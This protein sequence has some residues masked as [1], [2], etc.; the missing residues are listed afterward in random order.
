MM[1]HDPN[2][3]GNAAEL[4]IA[5][6]AGKLGLEV[7]YPL[8]EHGRADL[9]LGIAGKLYRVQCKWAN[10]KDGVIRVRLYSS[11]H[12]PTRGYVNSKYGAA[13]I[14]LIAVYCGDTARCYLV[15]AELFDGR[16]AL[17]LRVAPTKNKQRA[18]LN[19]A[20]D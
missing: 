11:Y 15:P 9:V 12:S 1:E 4:A 6:E 2:R 19:W 14:D 17:Y 10:C 8:T 16:A 3:K 20:S 18:A 7:L 13:E 5:A